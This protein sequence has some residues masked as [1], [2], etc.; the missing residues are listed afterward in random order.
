MSFHDLPNELFEPI[1]RE[2]VNRVGPVEAESY[3][4]VCSTE[5]PHFRFTFA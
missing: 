2:L 4:A 1:I 5:L 3:R